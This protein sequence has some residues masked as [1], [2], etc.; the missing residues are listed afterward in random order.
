MHVGD[1]PVVCLRSEKPPSPPR[2]GGEG[3]GAGAHE[4]LSAQRRAAVVFPAFSER[5]GA[6]RQSGSAVNLCATLFALALA[7]LPA[8]AADTLGPTRPKDAA[9]EIQEGNV[10]HWIKYY[11]RERGAPAAPTPAPQSDPQPVPETGPKPG[12][13][14]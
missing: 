14:R 1:E 10:E 6:R 7:L 13:Q 2:C 5:D 3:S 9:E 12:D 4:R 8:Y 11:Q